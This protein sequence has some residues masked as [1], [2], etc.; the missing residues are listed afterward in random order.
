MVLLTQQWLNGV[1]KDNINYSVIIDDGVTG[2]ATITAL[3]K[4][5]QIELGISTP[6]GNFGPAT[7]AAFGSLSINSQPQD[8][9]SNAEIISL[10]NK[11]FILQGAL[12]CN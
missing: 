4:A 10:Q 8:N 9:W 3:T 12:Y 7:S 11:I 1:Y 2:W 6:N 5:L